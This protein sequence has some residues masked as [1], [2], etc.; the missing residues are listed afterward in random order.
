[1][2]K[3]WYKGNIHTHTSMSDGDTDPYKVAG[4]FRRHGYDFLVLT[5]HDRLTRMDYGQGQR[6]YRKPLDRRP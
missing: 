6:R 1:M 2:A 4:W 5:D 3:N